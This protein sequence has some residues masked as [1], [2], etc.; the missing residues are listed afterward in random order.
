MELRKDELITHLLIET[1]YGPHCLHSL[2]LSA[3]F[4][5]LRKFPFQA[6]L[7]VVYQCDFGTGYV[8]NLRCLQ[9]MNNMC[10]KKEKM[11]LYKSDC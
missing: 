5:S 7:P 2:I 11:Q 8:L 1:V 3:S 6:L 10:G 9:F 4:L